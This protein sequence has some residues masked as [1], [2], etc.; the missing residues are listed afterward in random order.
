MKSKSR[1]FQRKTIVAVLAAFILFSMFFVTACG[2]PKPADVLDDIE[3]AYNSHDIY[4]MIA[5]YEPSVQKMAKGVVGLVSGL[6][7]IDG[8]ALMRFL[9]FLS[10]ALG[11]SGLLDE[12]D[13]GTCRIEEISTENV[14][15]I[16]AIL[17]YSVSLTYP[18]G[19]K[20][21][22]TDIGRVVKI[23]GGWYISIN[24]SGL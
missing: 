3:S 11:A 21:E 14:S 23:D 6:L 24:Q 10:K 15:D 4:A 22:F 17:T 19:S 13:W 5:C 1:N 7:G 9:P 16:E 20:T 2:G 8:D 18:D 12:N